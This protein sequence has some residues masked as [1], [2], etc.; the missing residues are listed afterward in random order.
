MRHI[1]NGAQ[2]RHIIN[3]FFILVSVWYTEEIT[4]F[5]C[6]EWKT[7]DQQTQISFHLSIQNTL[8]LQI[9]FSSSELP[10]KADGSFSSKGHAIIIKKTTLQCKTQSVRDRKQVH[11]KISV[12]Q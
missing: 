12:F 4:I 8:C 6:L 3:T 1:L 2:S 9:H 5:L 7:C 11:K 10:D